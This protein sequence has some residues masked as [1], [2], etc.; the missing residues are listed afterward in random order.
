[1][2]V[3]TTRLGKGSRRG[4]PRAGGAQIMSTTPGEGRTEQSARTVD[5][6]SH[7]PMIAKPKLPGVEM[8]TRTRVRHK[9]GS[10]HR[11]V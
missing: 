3:R 4:Q 6:P 11:K 10:S 5:R 1:M 7:R 8:P 2:A 9:H